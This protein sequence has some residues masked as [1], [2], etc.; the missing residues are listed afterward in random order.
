MSSKLVG[1]V[2]FF[3]ALGVLTRFATVH[4]VARF[5]PD[6]P[7]GTLI[8]NVIGSFIIGLVFAY[9]STRTEL[10]DIWR[11]ALVSGFLGGFTT[12]SSFSWELLQFYQE[13]RF[14]T[15]FLYGV[16]SPVLGLFAAYAGMVTAA[17]K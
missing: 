3:G 4:L 8:V 12:F 16:G 15:L 11:V 2:C 17:I 13:G 14:A 7:A 9:F 6:F 5:F 1:L 10:S